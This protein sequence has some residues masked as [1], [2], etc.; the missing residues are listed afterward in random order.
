MLDISF[1]L[2]CSLNPYNR[3]LYSYEEIRQNCN[4]IR[5]FLSHFFFFF[6]LSIRVKAIFSTSAPE[7]PPTIH[8]LVQLVNTQTG[9]N[10][11]KYVHFFSR[12]N[13]NSH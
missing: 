11:Q 12:K 13:M 9:H 1:W 4:L 7:P 3:S 10:I 5:R 6:V 2:D 8:I